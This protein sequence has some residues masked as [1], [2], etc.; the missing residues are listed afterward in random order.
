MKKIFALALLLLIASVVSSF[1]DTEAPASAN[2][3]MS[4]YARIDADPTS[5]T[6]AAAVLI[7]KCSKGVYAGWIVT[8]T[9]S[10]YTLTTQ[11]QS[12]SKSFGSSHDSTAI[13]RND[14]API[15][16]TAADSSFFASG[17]WT[18]M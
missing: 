8:A 16:P 9:G 2:A 7:G 12:G 5:S 13:Y 3:G 17:N 18:A 15:T 6:D 14:T 11:H 1:A 10:G 4:I